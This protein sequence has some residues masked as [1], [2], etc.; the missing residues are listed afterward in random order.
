MGKTIFLAS[1]FL[2]LFAACKKQKPQL[3]ADNPYGLPN[4][5]QSG[6]NI[7]A[8][9]INGENWISKESSFDLGGSVINDTLAAKGT[10]HGIGVETIYVL[11]KGNLQEGK[12]YNIS[13]NNSIIYTTTKLCNSNIIDFYNYLSN[14]GQIKLTKLDRTNKIIAGSFF[15]NV[16]RQNCNDTL[17]ITDGRFDIHYN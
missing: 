2:I 7:F 10:Y 5:T 4:A 6:V 9:R 16:I 3:Q 14:N 8:C 12:L 1:L 17:K 13:N 15:F 11:L